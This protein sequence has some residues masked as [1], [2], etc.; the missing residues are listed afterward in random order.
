MQDSEQTSINTSTGSLLNSRDERELRLFL[1]LDKENQGFITRRDLFR[2]IKQ[3]GIC[4]E[5]LRLKESIKSL[6]SYEDT[7]P[8]SYPEFCQIIRPNI[9][10]IEQILQANLIIPEF[11]ETRRVIEQLFETT[12]LISDG[13]VASYIP[14]LARVAPE[15]YAVSLCTIDGQR[16]S[17]G[18]Y[19][20]DFCIQS[21]CKP[22]NYCLALEENGQEKVHKHVGREPSGRGFN[23]LTLNYEGKPHNPMLNAGAIMCCSLIKPESNIADRFDYV[24]GQW[25]A[26]CGG[27]KVGFSNSVYLSERS[28][29]DRNF[30]LGYF[31][32]EN[33]AFPENT[34]L[35]A[36]LE[37]YFQCCSIEVNTEQMSIVAA[38]LANGGV[39]PITGK[40][41]FTPKTV[42]NCLSLMSSCGM[43]DF[44]GEFAFTV[45][46]PAKS[47][48]SGA[49]MIVVPNVMGISTWSP[50]VD[51][52]GNSVRGIAFCKRLVEAFNLHN[53]D[54]LTGLSEKKDPRRSRLDIETDRVIA[55]IWAASK[56]DLT[57]IQRLM[58]RGVDINGADYD[59]RTPLHL[60]SSEGHTHIVKYLINHN[61]NINLKDRWGNTPLDDAIQNNHQE[62]IKL[63]KSSTN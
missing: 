6:D 45:G 15:Q 5:D 23:E 19:Q 31:M 54:N 2:S 16:F 4:L 47:G 49:I 28:T 46:L 22:I 24:M 14:Q 50:R 33:K 17:L 7:D 20:T 25:K 34:D 51:R 18:D 26:L 13:E 60:A 32:R 62:I 53:Y 39:C 9:S 58:A 41:I 30:A 59:G 57:A 44:S 36:T 8:I 52:Q 40:R 48:V 55:M 61:V 27:A 1:A 10:L 38:T 21:C 42:Q 43:Y 11:T 63:L 37:F 29:A 56:G 3:T 35:I 12:K